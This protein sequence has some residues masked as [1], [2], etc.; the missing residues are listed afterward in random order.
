MSQFWFFLLFFFFPIWLQL[1][2]WEAEMIIENTFKILNKM[3]GDEMV[4]K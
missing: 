3:K 4:Y 1:Q 2:Q